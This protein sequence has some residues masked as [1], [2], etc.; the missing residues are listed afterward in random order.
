MLIC[1]INPSLFSAAVGLHFARPGNRFWRALHAGGLTDRLLRPEEQHVLPA[2]GI[3]ISNVVD[4]ATTRA[5]ELGR[6]EYVAGAAGLADKVRRHRPRWLA[7]AG[8]TAYRAAFGRP[9]ATYGPQ[10]EAVGG[11]PVWVLPNPSGLNAHWSAERLGEAY[12]ELR[13]AAFGTP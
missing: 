12:G 5:D 8:V 11:V 9:D 6:Q 7:I 13:V 3:G 4:R 2:Y 1:G 10:P